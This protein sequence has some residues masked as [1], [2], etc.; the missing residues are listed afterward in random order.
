MIIKKVIPPIMRKLTLQYIKI[1]WISCFV[2][3]LFYR[4]IYILQFFNES[5]KMRCKQNLYIK[6]EDFEKGS[7]S[8]SDDDFDDRLEELD[9]DD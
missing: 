2:E 9:L 8:F 6:M 1:Y 5:Y 7:K 3:N 4:R